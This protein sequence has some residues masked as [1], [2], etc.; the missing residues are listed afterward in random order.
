MTTLREGDLEMV[1]PSGASGRKFDDDT[2]GLSHCMKAVDFIVE[3]ADRILFIEFKDPHV[4]GA[5][6]GHEF[7]RRFLNGEIDRDLVTKF[8]DSFLYEWAANRLSKPVLYYV[9]VGI[10]DLDVGMIVERTD[11][12]QR[13]LPLNG[14]PSG[15]WAQPIAADCRVFSLTAWNRIQRGFPIRRISAA[16]P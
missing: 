1:L 8:R 9:L 13:K 7:V 5:R 4:P 14:P 12:L 16:R 10:E 11:A 2:H 15:I 3:L 6:F